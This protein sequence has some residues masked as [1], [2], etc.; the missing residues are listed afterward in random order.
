MAGLSQEEL[1]ERA[2]LS[3]RGI[4]DLERDLRQ[5]PYPATI[6]R[7]V[8]ALGL[9][10]PERTVMLA[11]SR[12]AG[13]TQTNAGPMPTEVTAAN[14]LAHNLPRQRTSFIAR[15]R[16]L[17]ELRRLLATSPLLTLTGPGGVGKT[18]LALQLA[19]AVLPEYAD[20]TWLVE[21]AALADPQ[22]VPQ[23]VAAA[24]RI[25]EPPGRRLVQVLAERLGSKHLLLVLDNCEHLV[26]ACAELSER[27]LG[28]CPQLHILATSRESLR[29]QGETMWRVRS[30]QVPAAGA[31][32]QEAGE[33]EAVRLFVERV[34]AVMAS[35]VLQARNVKDVAVVCR[36]LD[37]IPLAIELAAARVPALGVET[38]ARRQHDRLQLLVAGSR[39]APARQQTLR[40]TL[41]WSYD[42]L[43]SAEQRVFRGLAVFAGGCSL[44]TAE[45]VLGDDV[46]PILGA[47]VDKSLAQQEA[48]HD[49][50]VRFEL[51][52]SVRVF[53]LES[54]QA[55]GDWG[56]VHERQ[57]AYFVAL[58]EQAGPSLGGPPQVA[59][60]N[61]LEEE[62]DNLR[63]VLHWTLS[64]GAAVQGLRLGA[65]LTRLWYVRGYLTEGRRWLERLCALPANRAPTADRAR[66]LNGLGNLAYT[67]GDLRVARGAFEESLAIWRRLGD[68]WGTASVF[69]NLAY[70][71]YLQGDDTRAQALLDDCLLDARATGHRQAEAYALGNLASLAC[72]YEALERAEDLSR[73]A[74]DR[75]HELGDLWG[76]GAALRQ[77]GDI[78]RARGSLAEAQTWYEASLELWHRLGDRRGAAGVLLGLG[79]VA[80]GRRDDAAAQR[81]F[82]ACLRLAHDL[83]EKRVLAAALEGLAALAVARDVAARAWVLA[84]AAAALRA[85]SGVRASRVDRSLVAH[86]LERLPATRSVALEV[87]RLQVQPL[88][89]DQVVALAVSSLPDIPQAVIQGEGVETDPEP[90]PATPSGQPPL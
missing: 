85:E 52:Q 73:Q 43:N 32:L 53:A 37:G 55:S 12:R 82:S 30:L 33:S 89:L 2:G 8:E 58:A 72:E 57:A 35:F 54:L 81:D 90:E 66:A 61:R 31:A 59:W 46:L 36:G 65:M 64:S 86:W 68:R 7:V 78:A 21:L 34:H 23:S 62:H 42:L 75:F 71:A 20:G 4:S 14:R 26:D 17:V 77:H 51:L 45:A 19:E 50:D 28:A 24:L 29:I 18:R 49:Q 70:V 67:Q 83:G 1:A 39:T 88:D 38:L 74:L 3:K 87:N 47:L 76:Q 69:N 56:T 27:L 5:A 9:A 84:D 80:L 41:A 48:A 79:A 15:E 11:A 10:E 22:L 13:R 63:H 44:E 60:L 6:R 25:P 16:D 40:A